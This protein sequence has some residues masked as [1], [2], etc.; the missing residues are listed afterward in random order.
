MILKELSCLNAIFMMVIATEDI[1]KNF[2]KGGQCPLGSAPEI[3]LFILW[4]IFPLLFKILKI[5]KILYEMLH[6]WC[7]F[8]DYYCYLQSYFKFEIQKCGQILCAHKPYF[9]IQGHILCWHNRLRH[10]IQPCMHTH[11]IL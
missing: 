8:Y 7:E 11:I 4:Y 10:T 6:K 1:Y 3:H 9:L 2:L 5:C